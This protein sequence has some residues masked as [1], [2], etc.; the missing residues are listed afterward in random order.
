[1]LKQLKIVVR[2]PGAVAG[3]MVDILPTRND[4]CVVCANGD[5]Q[6]Y[7]VDFLVKGG[8]AE[9]VKDEPKEGET[10]HYVASCHSG[11]GELIP[12]KLNYSVDAQ[13]H[14]H[15]IDQGNWSRDKQ[16]VQDALDTMLAGLEDKRG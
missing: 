11:S 2:L 3:E 5:T 8:L 16:V 13:H 1:M 12:H 9:Y 15:I 6:F 7:N 4:I 14:K 10:V